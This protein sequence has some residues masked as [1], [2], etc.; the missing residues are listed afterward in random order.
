M[1]STPVS[2]IKII[3]ADSM[4]SSDFSDYLIPSFDKMI[5]RGFCFK[6]YGSGIFLFEDC[7]AC[8]GTGFFLPEFPDM[9]I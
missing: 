8:G 4:Y 5:E 9:E 3:N 2:D 6:C 7:F 1:N